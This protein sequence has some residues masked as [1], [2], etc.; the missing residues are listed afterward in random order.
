MTRRWALLSVVLGLAGTARAAEPTVVEPLPIAVPAAPE[1]DPEPAPGDIPSP[2]PAPVSVPVPAAVPRAAPPSPAAVVV[3]EPEPTSTSTS[4]ARAGVAAPLAGALTA[5]VPFIVGC[6]LWSSSANPE[7]ARVG[8]YVMA[9]GFAAAPWVSHGLQRRWRRAGAFGAL[10]AAT[11]AATLVAMNAKD[12]FD[13]NYVNR[14][15]VAFGM[16]LTSA[17]F[18][19]VIGVV[20]SFLVSEGP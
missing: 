14:Q 1:A 15:R 7:R 9:T 18:A 17:L 19:S 4:T 5:V 13:P 20:D 16:L 6:A 3:R 12:P 8:T 11:S 10:S 2:S